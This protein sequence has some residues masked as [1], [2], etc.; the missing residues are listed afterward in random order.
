M[1][2]SPENRDIFDI[3]LEYARLN[4]T[5]ALYLCRRVIELEEEI[6]AYYKVTDDELMSLDDALT[7]IGK[8]VGEVYDYVDSQEHMPDEVHKALHK[9]MDA[10]VEEEYAARE[11]IK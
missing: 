11:R 10:I 6:D 8:I 5:T 9:F 2:V 7:V 1:L 4:D 3:E